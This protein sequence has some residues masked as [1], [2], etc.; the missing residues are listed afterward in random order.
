MAVPILPELSAAPLQA[1]SRAS[2]RHRVTLATLTSVRLTNGEYTDTWV[3]EVEQAG[4]L[5]MGPSKLT[6]IAEAIGVKAEGTLRLAFGKLCEAGQQAM[7]RG[8]TKGIA[9]QRLVAL[10]SGTDLTNRLMTLVTVVDVD[11]NP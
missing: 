5:M 8:T 9:W 11:L 2:M 6:Q 7:V 1:I 4:L 10:T 3:D